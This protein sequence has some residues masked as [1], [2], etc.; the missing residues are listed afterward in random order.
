MQ[1]NQPENQ[2]DSAAVIAAYL[3]PGAMPGRTPNSVMVA[4]TGGMGIWEKCWSRLAVPEGENRDQV[5]YLLVR[6]GAA[7]AGP[8]RAMCFASD[9]ALPWERRQMDVSLEHHRLTPA[10][11]QAKRRYSKA[12]PAWP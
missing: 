10:G 3:D 8:M 12:A 11:I 4:G 9:L 6:S 5:E 2:P 1:V 7:R